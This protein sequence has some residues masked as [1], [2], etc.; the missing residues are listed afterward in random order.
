MTLARAEHGSPR[1]RVSARRSSVS[2]SQVREN[3]ALPALL[4]LFSGVAA[5]IFQILWIKQLTLVVG[6]EVHAIATGVGAFFAG[7][8]LGS[9]V[10]GRIA[11]RT[12]RPFRLYA[13]IEIVAAVLG[14]GTTILL[15]QAAPL[16][17]RLEDVSSALA[18]AI[19]LTAVALP[20]FMMGGTLPVLIRTMHRMGEGTAGCGGRLY[21][22]NT[23]GAVLGALLPPFLL[24][25]SLGVQGSALVAACIGLVLGCIALVL[26]RSREKILPDTNQRQPLFLDRNVVA[27]LALYGIA[28]AIALGYEIAWSQAIVPFTSTRAFAFSVVL[29]TYLVGLTLGS[30][31]FARH[32]DRIHDPWGAFGLLIAGAGTLALMGIAMPGRWLVVAQ[33][34]AEAAML[35]LTG[36]DLAGMCARFAV[37]AMA[38]VLPSTI[39]LGAAFPA[40]LRLIAVDKPSGQGTGAALA[41]N[42]VGGIAGTS[43][44]GFVLIPTLG[45]VRTLGLLAVLAAAIGLIAAVRGGANR[46]LKGAALTA[47]CL[48]VAVAMAIP[49]DRLARVFPGL[50]GGSLAFYEEGRGGTVAVV[51]RGRGETRFRRLYIQGVSNSGD[52]MPSLRYMRLQALLPLI[53]HN[54]EPRSALV[55]GY[56]TGITA[57][58]LLRYPDLDRR[59]VAEL[60][61]AVLRAAPLFK[62]TFGADSDPRMDIRL[63]DGRRELQRSDETYDLITLEPPPPSAAGVVNLYSRDF[64]QLAAARLRPQGM[65]AQWLPLPTQNAEDTRSLVRSFL[66]VFPYVTLWT[67]ELHEMLLMGSLAPITLD[68]TRIRERATMSEVASTLAEVG[69]QSPEALLATYVMGREGLVQFAGDATA[70]TDDR[71]R[72]EYATWVRRGDFGLVLPDLLNLRDEVPVSGADEASLAA[73]ASR[74]EELL[75]FYRAGMYAFA[76]NRIG[77]ARDMRGVLTA[78]PN[79]PYYRWFIRGEP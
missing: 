55:I 49:A 63:R 38:V 66:D 64:Y 27:A 65:V 26:D 35:A 74:R 75:T 77:W 2:R 58:A 33:T 48:S 61:P 16:F 28:G 79:N 1:S 11:D 76:G 73:I 72:I 43:M 37:A 40:A 71:P 52:A 44:T 29:A 20:A 19:P 32:A 23:F 21:A 3:N 25:P 69:I 78:D 6:V 47:A 41:V 17:A 13:V 62:G 4:L 7:L 9:L 12:D 22:A 59:V 70:V 14:V 50:R 56:G 15:A 10:W 34:G 60:L 68:L 39:L 53:I 57:G 42:T 24:I 31:L 8:G 36:N 54:G 46:R 67:T 30:A 51:E 45:V 18:W 5:L